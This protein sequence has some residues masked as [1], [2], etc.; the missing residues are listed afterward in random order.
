M[1][2][3]SNI[4]IGDKSQAY[5]LVQT[6]ERS[7]EIAQQIMEVSRNGET[8]IGV[9]C[10]GILRGRPLCL[11]QIFF[12]GCTYVFDLL[13]FNPFS[14]MLREVLES[15]NIIKIFH[16]FCEDAASLITHYGIRAEKVF[17]TQI[18]HRLLTNALNPFKCTENNSV[19]LNTLLKTHLE[20]LNEY[21]DFMAKKLKDDITLWEKRPLT[22][23]MI[24][25]AAQDVCYLPLVYKVFCNKVKKLSGVLEF[26][27]ISDVFKDSRKCNIYAYININCKNLMAC[28]VGQYLTA[29]LKNFQRFCIFCSLNLGCTGIVLDQKSLK[30]I[31]TYFQMGDM[32]NLE[33]V[34]I[35]IEDK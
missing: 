1:D 16:D 20:L 6:F 21:K 12:E 5:E 15:N 18:A 23:E 14:G 24:N 9:D 4:K 3:N 11:I 30:F 10:E 2:N 32:L 28:K 7:E 22:D 31:K 29:F 33:I 8:V 13:E 35:D 27:L 19:S 25:Y 17:D 34:R 26:D